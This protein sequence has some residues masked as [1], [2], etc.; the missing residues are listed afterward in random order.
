MAHL[1]IVGAGAAGMTAAGEALRLG[2]DVTLFYRK[3]CIRICPLMQPSVL[4]CV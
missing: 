4:R 1:L 2:C 3:G